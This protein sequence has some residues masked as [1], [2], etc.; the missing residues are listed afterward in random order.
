MSEGGNITVTAENVNLDDGDIPEIRDGK[1]IMITISDNG[2]GIDESIREKIFD[3]FF[4]TKSTGTGLGLSMCYSIIRKHDG[5]IICDSQSGKG[6]TFTIYLPA[7]YHEIDKDSNP[8]EVNHA[9]DGKMLLVDDEDYILDI[10]SSMVST[11]GYTPVSASDGSEAVNYCLKNDVD[12]KNIKCAILDLTI[13]GGM[14]GKE[15]VIHLKKLLPGI[16][17]IATSGYSDDPVMSNPEKFG[18]SGSLR[19]P[20]KIQELAHTLNKLLND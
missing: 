2:S 7:S 3:P 11:L 17:I 15:T 16:P 12:L 13:P 5:H 18:F 4:S 8:L 9:G 19:K 1:Y 10:F 6:T 14:G 20:F